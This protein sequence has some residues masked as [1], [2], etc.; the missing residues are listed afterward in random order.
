MVYEQLHLC[1]R[2][3]NV[4]FGLVVNFKVNIN[5]E[6]THTNVVGI[7]WASQQENVL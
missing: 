1:L 7:I 4:H 3:V 2:R 6:N 5:V